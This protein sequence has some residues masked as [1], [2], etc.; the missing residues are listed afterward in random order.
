[1]ANTYLTNNN[2][3][4]AV[5]ALFP[6][7]AITR[8]CTAT[9]GTTTLTYDVTTAA[10]ILAGMT[11]TGAGITSGGLVVSVNYT[12]GV[13]TLTGTI[14][15]L[16]VSAYVFTMAQWASLHTAS[17]GQTG[18]NEASGGSYA[19]QSVT[20]GIAASGVKASTNSQTFTAMPSVT[21]TH[22]GYWSAVS[23]GSWNGGTA[24]GSSL[25]VP[26]GATVSA[27]VGALTVAVQG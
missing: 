10:L 6:S 1:V 5:E 15:T 9:N 12:T 26:S 19:R 20:L 14:T 8:T 4:A 18:A 27:A 23:G 24:L 3:N 2:S 21:I 11:V 13:V 22:Q 16:T 7:A 17:P 25:V